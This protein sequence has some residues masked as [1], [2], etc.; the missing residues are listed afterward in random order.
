MPV[1]SG[2]GM[3][4]SVSPGTGSNRPAFQSAFAGAIR[5]G[6]D[7]TKFH[8]MCRGPSIVSP[9]MTTKRAASLSVLLT[10]NAS[11]GRNTNNCP[12]GTLTRTRVEQPGLELVEFLA[13]P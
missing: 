13:R 12:D 8:Q 1:L 5:S 9:P 11:F 10:V 4:S 2:K 6:R 7:D 3:N